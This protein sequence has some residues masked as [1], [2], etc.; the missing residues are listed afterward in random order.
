[1]AKIY[2]QSDCNLSILKDKTV[3]ILVTALRAMPTPSTCMKAAS[4]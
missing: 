2:Y 3:A 4:M 1:M